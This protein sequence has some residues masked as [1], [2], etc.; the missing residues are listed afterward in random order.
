MLWGGKELSG[1]NQFLTIALNSLFHAGAG[2]TCFMLI[3]GYF[4]AKISPYRLVRLWLI[5]EICSLA[6]TT[7][8]IFINDGSV[9]ALAKAAIPITTKK[10]W[11]ASCYF[12]TL[13]LSPFLNMAVDRLEKSAYRKLLM[14]LILLFY[15]FPTFLYYDIIGDKGKGLVHMVIA[16]FIGRY[17]AL[18]SEKHALKRIKFFLCCVMIMSLFGNIVATYIRKIT[19]WPFSRECTIT[20]LLIAVCCLIIAVKQ[21]EHNIKLVNLVAKYVFPVYLLN[22]SI[23][24]YVK[25][26]FDYSAFY[27]ESWYIGLCILISG[28]VFVTSFIISIPILKIADGLTSFLCSILSK[29]KIKSKVILLIK[30]II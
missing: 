9:L 25:S 8:S 16:Y 17:M 1:V 10:Y 26:V 2:T 12:Y 28:I 24:G 30:K 6:T 18:F 11:Y 21:T 20:T 14:L 29:S 27:S 7:F 3:T 23:I 22:N 15:A 4:G 5:V 13:L 19:S